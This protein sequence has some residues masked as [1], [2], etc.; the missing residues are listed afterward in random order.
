M[1]Q[2]ILGTA[3]HIDHGKTSLIRAVTGID[4]DRLKEE[5]LRG[6]TIELGFASLGL[7]SGQRMGI[8]D[9]PGHEKFVKNMVA[10]A[11]GID[12]VAMVIAADEGVMPQTREHMEICGLLGI[13]HGLVVLTKIDMVDEEWLELISEDVADFVE[14]TFLEGA[15]V[16]RVSSATGDG[17]PEFLSVLDQLSE[18][19]PAR[20]PTGLFRLPVDRVFTMRGFGTVVTGTLMAG[21]VKVGETVTIY[22]SGITSKVRGLQVHNQSVE[23]ADAGMRTAVNFQG[24]EKSAV[25][26]GDVVSNP[27]AL[28]PSYMVDISLTYLKSNEKPLKNRTRVRFH[29]GTCEI[30]GNIILLEADELLPGNTALAQVRMDSPVALVKDDRFVIR[31]YSPIRT[32]GGGMVLNPA[33]SKHK[34]FRSDVLEGLSGLVGQEYDKIISFHV[35]QSG[36]AG[37]GFSQLKIMTNLGDGPLTKTIQALL[38]NRTIL[39]ADKEQQLYVH[40]DTTADLVDSITET[41]AAY[42]KAHPLKSG[43]PREELKSKLPPSLGA[44]LFGLVL[45]QME[46]DENIAVEDKTVRLFSHTVSLGGDQKDIRE[47]ILKAY[48]ESGLTPPYFKELAKSLN[49]DPKRAHDVLMHLVSEGDI[50]RIKDDLFYY[51]ASLSALKERLVAYLQENGEISTPQFKDLTGASRKFVIP[52]IEYFDTVNVTIRVGDI[53]KLRKG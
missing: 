16:V 13:R 10:G 31:S 7:P 22:P 20:Q 24:V 1:K 39:L 30:L 50:V 6:I 11:T 49:V 43:M 42:H 34:R 25:N 53:R 33:P 46:K 35:S 41:L 27:E 19:I 8:V 3:G 51:N 36:P 12:L 32:I 5:K 47:K 28:Q 14:G 26:R 23:S 38:S 15:P 48:E 2:I 37:L 52:L 44:K 18:S 29:S 45:R 21:R 4:T 9:V 17:I 40:Q